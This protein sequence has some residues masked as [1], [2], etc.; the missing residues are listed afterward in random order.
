M[1]RNKTM[2]KFLLNFGIS[3]LAYVI[4]NYAAVW[5]RPIIWEDGILHNW[6]LNSSL[7][8]YK[9]ALIALVFMLNSGVPVILYFFI[10]TKLA[11]LKNYY[12]NYLSVS[13]S[14]VFVLIFILFFGINFN[15]MT[16]W[17][18]NSSY[19]ITMIYILN[20]LKSKTIGA[21]VLAILPSINI[22]L[23]MLRQ[24]EGDEV[25]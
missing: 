16:I 24:V 9:W 15:K 12:L 6:I 10:G 3:F 18:V 11:P 19:G 14:F 13:G 17:N 5:M 4:I 25:T 23:G 8:N 20:F 22:W 21:F 1:E 7:E 2:K